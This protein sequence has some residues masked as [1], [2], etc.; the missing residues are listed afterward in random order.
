MNKSF[1]NQHP[2]ILGLLGAVVLMLPIQAQVLAP[3]P[4]GTPP[5]VGGDPLGQPPIV[6]V[7]P[8]NLPQNAQGGTQ[9]NDAQLCVD[10][11]Q[12]L[13]PCDQA[14]GGGNSNLTNTEN[15]DY[16]KSPL[17]DKAKNNSD[18]SELARQQALFRKAILEGK[19]NISTAQKNAKTTLPALYKANEAD[20]AKN[21]DTKA[22]EAYG[23]ASDAFVKAQASYD[24]A[25]ATPYIY[26]QVKGTNQAQIDFANAQNLKVVA[27]KVGLDCQA[28]LGQSQEFVQRNLA[29]TN[30]Q[31]TAALG[32]LQRQMAEQKQQEVAKDAQQGRV[33]SGIQKGLFQMLDGFTSPPTA[34]SI[35]PKG[36]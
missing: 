24:A 23:K 29:E 2:A 32:Q 16:R 15:Y 10:I 33:T 9:A 8:I 35:R 5:L 6:G 25:S 31:N 19:D 11:N 30:T 36:Y 4:I 14:N 7:P 13:V 20:V 21:C 27:D 22:V 3:A 1:M 17:V 26:D 34:G 18:E 12:G 28:A